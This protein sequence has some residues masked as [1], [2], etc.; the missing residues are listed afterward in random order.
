MATPF[1]ELPTELLYQIIEL[2]RP[3]DFESL[4]L[5]SKRVYDVG[6]R[7]IPAHNYCKDLFSRNSHSIFGSSFEILD[8]LT[9]AERV[10]QWLNL[11]IQYLNI[12][13][14]AFTLVRPGDV[15]ERVQ[16]TDWLMEQF[17]RV[18][19]D[20]PE[21]GRYRPPNEQNQVRQE[22]FYNL[23]IFPLLPNLRMLVLDSMPNIMHRFDL[24]W[25]VK[26]YKMGQCFPEL[27]TLELSRQTLTKYEHII[28][29]LHSLPKLRSL[30][31]NKPI[32]PDNPD[33]IMRQLGLDWPLGNQRA[34]PLKHLFFLNATAP[35]ELVLGI[36]ERVEALEVFMWE[37]T[38]AYYIATRDSNASNVSTV[39]NP[40]ATLAEAPAPAT[41]EI[42][43]RE[44]EA[45]DETHVDETLT[46]PLRGRHGFVT[47]EIVALEMQYENLL[48]YYGHSIYTIYCDRT[49]E[50][51]REEWDPLPSNVAVEEDNE[52]MAN[53]PSRL[54]HVRGS[55]RTYRLQESRL[56][57]P[58]RLVECLSQRFA[59][60]LKRLTL[61]VSADVANTLLLRQHQ[62]SN[63]RGFPN[64]THLEFDDEALRPI[65]GSFEDYPLGWYPRPLVA[66]L[67]SSLKALRL[68]VRMGIFHHIH[69]MLRDLP[70]H[71]ANF[72]SLNHITVQFAEYMA[73]YETMT[74]IQP[75]EKKF[76]EAGV[77]LEM[78][79]F[80]Y[81]ET[82][83]RE[84]WIGVDQCSIP[85]DLAR[86]Y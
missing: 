81:T 11:Y 23:A 86:I 66:V 46:Q 2:S 65:K 25:L 9:E 3:L 44:Q 5:T 32:P 72:A 39:E 61:T 85:F 59:A 1:L 22:L 64:L 30:L 82:F 38:A 4:L 58:K 71:K 8:R 19:Q 55:G 51:I 16:H 50:A 62:I 77:R 37:E 54:W 68:N 13:T 67:P 18:A 43:W 70:S 34:L 29:W 6:Q 14:L 73:P 60:S 33:E 79:E 57:N 41:Y 83:H 17:E 75:L 78:K 31:V 53:S 69:V 49:F 20:V 84:A 28:T 21:L 7:L 36:L 15:M 74:R 52:D 56:F 47:P 42:S 35:V 80:G 12:N 24:C 45:A 27:E 63:F 76:G 40:A 10:Y 26:Q 48:N